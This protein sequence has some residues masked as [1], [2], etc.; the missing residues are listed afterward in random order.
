[1]LR[2]FKLCHVTRDGSIDQP[3]HSHQDNANPDVTPVT[4]SV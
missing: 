2:K 3:G 4:I 1:M